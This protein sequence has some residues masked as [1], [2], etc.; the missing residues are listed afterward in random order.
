MLTSL[1]LVGCCSKL[2][3][4]VGNPFYVRSSPIK[5][6]KN[7]KNSMKTSLNR[8]LCVKVDDDVLK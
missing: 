8:L 6:W 3:R 5:G 7:G 4:P 2:A 1:A